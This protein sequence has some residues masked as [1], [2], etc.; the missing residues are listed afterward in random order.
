MTY[1]FV[2]F[3]SF[4]W[5]QTPTNLLHPFV[6]LYEGIYTE[7]LFEGLMDNVEDIAPV[8]MLKH[9]VVTIVVLVLQTWCSIYC[10]YVDDWPWNS[11]SLVISA[12]L[13]KI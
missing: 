4:P 9:S 6:F 5:G 11:A 2:V 3:T 12:N 10:K 7:L 13:K 1:N 8:T